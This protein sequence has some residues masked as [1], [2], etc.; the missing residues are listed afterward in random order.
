MREK[1]KALSPLWNPSKTLMSFIFGYQ[2]PRSSL[3]IINHLL[4]ADD[5]LLFPTNNERKVENLVNLIRLLEESSGLNI[6]RNNQ[7]YWLLIAMSLLL[8]SLNTKWISC[9][10]RTWVFPC[11][12]N[13][14]LL[15]FGSL[16]WRRL[17]KDWAYDSTVF[18]PKVAVWLF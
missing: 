16:L 13:H 6:N 9:K 1:L 10:L 2:V 18:S 4:F 5:T 17:I 15:L 12:E 11:M 7:S 14:P 3:N 8:Q